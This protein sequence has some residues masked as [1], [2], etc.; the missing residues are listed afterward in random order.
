MNAYAL[1]LNALHNAIIR[2]EATPA[3]ALVAAT[4]TSEITPET[5][6]SV[7]TE[8]YLERLAEAITLDF[9]AL[10]HY[11]GAGELS[12]LAQRYATE[13]PSQC[14][15][16][17]QYPFGFV[18][19]LADKIAADA[20]SIAQ[21]EGAV[22]EVFWLP[23]S[24][25][26]TAEDLMGLDEEALGLAQFSLRKAAKLLNLTHNANDYLSAFREHECQS[27][28]AG[29]G[30]GDAMLTLTQQPQYVLVIRSDYAVTREVLEPLEYHVLTAIDAGENFNDALLQAGDEAQLAQ[31]LPE[32][33]AR[34]LNLGVFQS[35]GNST[36]T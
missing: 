8:G 16:L 24:E 22:S 4:R 7:Y 6:L 13:H 2:A 11:T 19:W 34:W 14:W 25:P 21:I 3:L 33:I 10:A 1:Q 32:Y 23:E 17:N 35:G 20:Y 18:A 9:P 5:R 26:L 29:A 30:E 31:K 28:D 36:S 27:S 12:E 15:D